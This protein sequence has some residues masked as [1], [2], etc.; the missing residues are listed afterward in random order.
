MKIS[1]EKEIKKSQSETATEI[2]DVVSVVSN[3]KKD[4]PTKATSRKSKTTTPRKTVAKKAQGTTKKVE[5]K[6]PTTTGKRVSKKATQSTENKEVEKK[7]EPTIEYK[8]M[9]SQSKEVITANAFFLLKKGEPVEKAIEDVKNNFPTYKPIEID[10]IVRQLYKDKAEFKGFFNKHIND[11]VIQYINYYEPTLRKNLISKDYEREYEVLSDS[12]LNTILI[13]AQTFGIKCSKDKFHTILASNYLP[14]YNPLIEFFEKHSERKP[15]GVIKSLSDSIISPIMVDSFGGNEDYNERFIRRWL[16]G[17]VASVFGGRSNLFLI[18]VGGQGTGKSEFFLRLL[19]K[20]LKRYLVESKLNNEK[21]SDLAQKMGSALI[22][23]DDEMSGK[24]KSDWKTLKSLSDQDNFR[25]RLPYDRL[26]VSIK[27][28]ASFA[29]TSNDY[30]LLGDLT[31]NRRLLPIEVTSI[32]HDEYNAV[33]KIDLLLEA[34]HLYK[35][36]YTH[37]LSVEDKELLNRYSDKFQITDPIMEIIEDCMEVPTVENKESAKAMTSTEIA[38]Y[39]NRFSP[40]KIYPN[41]LGQRLKNLHFNQRHERKGKTTR[42]FYDV[43]LL[44]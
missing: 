31:G 10:D 2:E 11:Q 1:A 34:Y 21:E 7:T 14:M 9:Y 4:I 24:N 3:D 37:E 8:K 15:K 30:E 40:V 42:R 19:P 28:L 18:L 33:D 17:L 27:R 43:I 39:L 13:D 38:T 6:K 22:I 35:E 32:L 20:Q 29:G 12:D 36:G 41:A 5:T 16:V 44:K 23:F 25:V 26:L